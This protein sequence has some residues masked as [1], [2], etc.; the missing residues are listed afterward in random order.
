[1]VRWKAESEGITLMPARRSGG[2][3]LRQERRC[4]VLITNRGSITFCTMHMV[5]TRNFAKF[6]LPA[7]P[8]SVVVLSLYVRHVIFFFDGYTCNVGNQSYLPT[9]LT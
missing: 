6:A 2:L 3:S 9:K 7:M 1:M 5:K 4:K 8:E